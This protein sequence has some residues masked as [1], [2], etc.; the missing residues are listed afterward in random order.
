MRAAKTLKR[1]DA[2]DFLR[3]VV[4]LP[5]TQQGFTLLEALAAIVM[6]G[7]LSVMIIPFFQ[8]GITE[9]HRPAEWLQEA[10]TLKRVMENLNARYQA[11]SPKNHGALINLSA[12]I[13]A[14]GASQDNPFGVYTV[15]ENDFIRFNG[16]GSEMSGGTR[17]LKVSI[18]SNTNPGYRV[19]PAFYGSV[20]VA[21]FRPQQNQKGFTLVEIIAALVVLG[22]L[23]VLGGF[24]LGQAI[25]GYVLARDNSH[26]SQK[27]QA[28]LDR[29]GVEFSHIIF[30]SHHHRYNIHAGHGDRL[31]YTANFGGN[32]ETHRIRQ[33][34]NEVRLDNIP[35]VDQVAA[36]DGFD[37]IFLDSNGDSVGNGASDQRVRMIGINLTMTGSSGPPRRFSTRVALQR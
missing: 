19:D 6:A 20:M 1:I 23:A 24:G 15:L 29:L 10:V 21:Q 22:L 37:L 9:S 32:D 14:P 28:A 17:I 2:G 11:L 31:T 27:A 36:N 18:R 4:C 12:A 35:L 3:R 34:G 26:L 13:G 30:D 5:K 7:V 33:V 25:N 8:S 16:A